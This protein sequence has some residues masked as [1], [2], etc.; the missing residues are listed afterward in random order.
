MVLPLLL[1]MVAKIT[2]HFI[3]QWGL[4]NKR[5]VFAVPIALLLFYIVAG[6][7]SKDLQKLNQFVEADNLAE[8]GKDVE[9]LYTESGQ[10]KAKI[11]TDELTRYISNEGITEFKKGLK[12]YFYDANGQIESSMTAN[13]GKAFEAEEELFARNNVIV[14]NVKG[15]KLNT[16]ELIWKRKDK[17]IFS[18][19]F[20]KIT[21]DDEI[22]FGEGLEAN[23]DFS[24][25]VIKKVKGS[26]K[27]DAKEFKEGN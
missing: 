25:Y 12:I 19:K 18:N 5:I 10:A 11:L 27:V 8:T 4:K 26:I 6:S 7:G 16:E 2:S 23:E 20:V 9:I 21:T 13:Y 22:I 14:I 24:D 15:E 1:R 17:K 3:F